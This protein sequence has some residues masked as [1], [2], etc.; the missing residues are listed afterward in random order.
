MLLVGALEIVLAVGSAAEETGL[1]SAD[2]SRL[3][4]SAEPSKPD[5]SPEPIEEETVP[6]PQAVINKTNVGNRISFF[7]FL[8]LGM[9]LFYIL[10]K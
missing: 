10:Q 6:P 2:V 9:R 5:W 7:I 3:V 4:A 1:P 8:P